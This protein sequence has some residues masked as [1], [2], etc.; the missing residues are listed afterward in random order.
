[1]FYPAQQRDLKYR[2]HL[3]IKQVILVHLISFWL[4][5]LIIA[6]FFIQGWQVP[7]QYQSFVAVGIYMIINFVVLAIAF[8]IK[9]MH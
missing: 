4:F 6:L 9:G 7:L 8:S 1:M 2:A 3:N 5:V